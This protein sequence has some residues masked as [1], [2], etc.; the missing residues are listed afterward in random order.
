MVFITIST[1]D[2]TV[3]FLPITIVILTRSN[4]NRLVYTV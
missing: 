2:D 1:Q 3:L 4:Y